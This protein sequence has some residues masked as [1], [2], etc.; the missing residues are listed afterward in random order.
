MARLRKGRSEK[1]WLE[2]GQSL[3]EFVGNSRLKVAKRKSELKNEIDRLLKELNQAKANNEQKKVEQLVTELNTLSNDCGDAWKAWV[4]KISQ[5]ELDKKRDRTDLSLE[6]ARYFESLIEDSSK[7]KT[8]EQLHQALKLLGVTS[9]SQLD[10]LY[11]F[12]IQ[13]E[14]NTEKQ[15]NTTSLPE[16][17]IKL[18]DTRALRLLEKGLKS[19]GVNSLEKLTHWANDVDTVYVTGSMVPISDSE[20]LSKSQC[21]PVLDGVTKIVFKE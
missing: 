17:K 13:F 15:A 10:T 7:A 1:E 19:R 8:Y 6:A 2:C 21:E 14:D 11:R 9:L 4:K 12:F 18:K 16:Q 20:V 3:I 5:D